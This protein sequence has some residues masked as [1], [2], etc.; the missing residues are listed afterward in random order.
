[1]KKSPGE[2]A[3]KKKILS[4]KFPCEKN[5]PI[6]IFSR[7][8]FVI[9]LSCLL[10]FWCWE[11]GIFSG[12][13]FVLGGN[14]PWTSFPHTRCGVLK[15]LNCF[16]P[17]VSFWSASEKNQQKTSRDIERNQWHEMGYSN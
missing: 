5:F 13:N 17:L 6:L 15:M 2:T 14:S 11:E 8:I 12:G 4:G 3:F 16:I 10:C 9:F 1:M 7:S